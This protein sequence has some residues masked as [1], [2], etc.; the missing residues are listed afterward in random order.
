MYVFFELIYNVIYFVLQN[1][2]G[3]FPQL[4][5]NIFGYSGSTDWGLKTLS[6][7][8]REF[9]FVRRFLS[10]SGAVFKLID[11]LQADDLHRY[12]FFI[13]CLPVSSNFSNNRLF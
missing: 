11:M 4:L 12:E 1:L 3:F 8:S 7:G 2:H 9:D 10:P 13:S 6:R 5:S